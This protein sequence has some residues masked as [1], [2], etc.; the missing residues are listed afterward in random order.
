MRRERAVVRTIGNLT[1]NPFPSGKG[2]RIRESNLF[3]SGKGTGMWKVGRGIGKN[4]GLLM[5][6]GVD[7]VEVS[8]HAAWGLRA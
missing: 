3:P 5:G 2:N 1:P 8:L 4:V 7:T 6:E